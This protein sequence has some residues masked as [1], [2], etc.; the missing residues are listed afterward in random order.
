MTKTAIG[1]FTLK[2]WRMFTDKFDYQRDGCWEWKAHR[3]GRG[4]GTFWTGS[5]KML[6]HRVSWEWSVGKRIP[7][8][9]VI[10]HLCRNKACVNPNHL[11]PVTDYENRVVRGNLRNGREEM[12][13]CLRGHPFDEGNTYRYERDGKPRRGCR[14]CQE[15][16]TARH[17][18]TAQ[19]GDLPCPECDQTFK[20]KR[21]VSIHRK[22]AH[23]RVW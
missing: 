22:R 8:G 21:G 1:D 12:T 10:D 6:A 2:R 13:H 5:S 20:S 9:L 14:A 19:A 4:Y 23:E 16:R 15:E 7:E 18:L 11:E 17:R 3:N